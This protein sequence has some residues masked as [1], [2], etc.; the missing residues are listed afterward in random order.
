MG[1]ETLSAPE[2]HGCTVR[3][4]QP[5]DAAEVTE[6]VEAVYGNTYYP[7]E[8]YNPAEIV[9]LNAEDKLVSVVTVHDDR[10]IVGHYALER[11]RLG[12]V[13]EA[14]DAIVAVDF[15]RHH[16]MEEMRE[17]LRAQALSI[18]L[19]GIVGYP[20]TNHLFSQMAEDHF[21]AHPCGIA[22]GLWPRSFHNMPEPLPQRMS[23]VIYFKYLRPVTEAV[24]VATAHR[25]M[26]ERIAG[27]WSVPVCNV[28]P[29]TPASAGQLTI[30]YEAPVETGSIHV[31]TVGH[32]SAGSLAQAHAKLRDRGAKAISLELPLA[33]AGT[34]E[35]CRA[36]EG[37]SYFFCG[38]GPSFA[39]DGDA[40]L[41]QYLDEDL[42]AALILIE[43]P[44]AKGL[45]AYVDK[46]RKRAR[47]R[48]SGI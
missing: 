5:G 15:R 18:G 42:D 40:L 4:F 34:A 45:L 33:Q 46:E 39:A 2:A 17:V 28:A 41:L 29:A 37:L 13:A 11:P 30:E 9:R 24:H 1:E 21:G 25:A 8:L 22:P 27:Q 19:T 26:L 36:A 7:T 6:L 44:L 20:V 31:H 47:S 3:R 10:D 14:S 35:L 12:R 32:D 48:A 38:L 43:N 16:L 23:F